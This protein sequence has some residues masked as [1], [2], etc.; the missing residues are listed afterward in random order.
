MIAD[1]LL[2]CGLLYLG[3]GFKRLTSEA[4]RPNLKIY[5]ICIN[6]SLDVILKCRIELKRHNNNDYGC[7]IY[8]RF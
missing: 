6:V 5:N 2:C 7:V 1:N 8:I 3:R 4:N